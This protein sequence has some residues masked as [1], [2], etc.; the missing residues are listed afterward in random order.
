MQTILGRNKLSRPQ[1]NGNAFRLYNQSHSTTSII[2][3]RQLTTL[4][5]PLKRRDMHLVRASI[6]EKAEVFY[7]RFFR[8]A[9]CIWEYHF[10]LKIFD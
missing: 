9:L 10:E 4:Y 8:N 2:H 5:P 3:A 1:W 7:V 6:C